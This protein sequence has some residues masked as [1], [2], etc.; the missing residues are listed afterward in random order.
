MALVGAGMAWLLPRW[1]WLGSNEGF[2]L[3]RLGW[4]LMAAWAVSWLVEVMAQ[5]SRPVADGLM[6][7]GRESLVMY[8]AHLL[9]IHALPLPQ[10]R[11]EKT[12]SV[13]EVVGVFLLLLV[14]SAGLAWANAW[15]K[16]RGKAMSPTALEARKG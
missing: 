2:F 6:L 12:L 8:V 1:D 13:P 15:R 10:F 14:L 7:A 11:L 9:M 4:V 3:Q 5:R 16:Q